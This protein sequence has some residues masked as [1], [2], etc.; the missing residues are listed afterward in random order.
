MLPQVGVDALMRTVM[1]GDHTAIT[2]DALVGV[3]LGDRLVVDV[4]IAPSE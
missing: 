2:A 3:N 1:T 4:E